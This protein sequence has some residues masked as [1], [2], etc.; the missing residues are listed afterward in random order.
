L[1]A[2]LKAGCPLKLN[3]PR[4]RNFAALSEKESVQLMAKKPLRRSIA[5]VSVNEEGEPLRDYE[6]LLGGREIIEVEPEFTGIL[7]V[8]GNPLF[9]ARQ[10]IGFK[11][12]EDGKK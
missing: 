11:W 12:T 5:W 3:W 1:S 10:R 9:R 8:Q 4:L 2:A 6:T 7:D